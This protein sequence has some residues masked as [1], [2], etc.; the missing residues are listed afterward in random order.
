MYW[1]FRKRSIAA[2]YVS[3]TRCAV[4]P[5]AAHGVCAAVDDLDHSLI[6]GARV[7]SELPQAPGALKVYVGASA[8][9]ATVIEAHSGA[10]SLSE[11][12][13]LAAHRLALD[14][15]WTLRCAALM[16]SSGVLAIAVETALVQNVQRLAETLGIRCLRIEPAFLAALRHWD[17]AHGQACAAIV[18]EPGSLITAQTTPTNRA[19]HAQLSIQ[20]S[21]ALVP[22]LAREQT[23]LR[24]SLGESAPQHLWQLQAEALRQGTPDFS[25]LATTS[26]S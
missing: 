9:R 1:P 5:G 21:E 15:R 17:T 13:A 11:A 7:L 4:Q 2:W 14:A 3:H 6:H 10:R 8:L 25:P 24:L 23:R 26:T 18:V 19:M 20:A 16:P 22:D 12:Q